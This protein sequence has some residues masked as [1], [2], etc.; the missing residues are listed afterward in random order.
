MVSVTEIS[1]Q[2]SAPLPAIKSQ[3]QVNVN[4][5]I[6][7]PRIRAV[8]ERRSKSQSRSQRRPEVCTDII[9]ESTLLNHVPAAGTRV[10]QNIKSSS[11]FM[12][13]GACYYKRC[14]KPRVRIE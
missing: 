2:V 12:S 10:K 3:V 14:H 1:E 4:L 11:V 5:S 6:N 8:V 13:T 7:R 9:V